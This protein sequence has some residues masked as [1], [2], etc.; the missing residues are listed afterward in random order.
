MPATLYLTKQDESI[1]SI[2]AIKYKR[3]L[4]KPEE[5][6]KILYLVISVFLFRISQSL[7]LPPELNVTETLPLQKPMQAI[8]DFLV[9]Q[10]LMLQ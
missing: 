2:T 1:N 8:N 9:K 7:E 5:N 3:N 10:K 4:V 6:K